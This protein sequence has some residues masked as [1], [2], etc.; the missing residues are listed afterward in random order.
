MLRFVRFF[1]RGVLLLCLLLPVAAQDNAADILPIT[2]DVI[3]TVRPSDTLDA[4]GALFDVSPVCIAANNDISRYDFLQIGQELLISV[5]C[6][7][8]AEDPSYLPTNTVLVPRDVVDI[9]ECDGVRTAGSDTIAGLARI[10][11][12]TEEALREANDLAVDEEPIFGTCITIPAPADSTAGAGG[13]SA[14]EGTFYVVGFGDTL[15]SIGLE[16]N[17]SAVSLQIANQITDVRQLLAG[18]TLFIPADAPPFG[19]YPPL[20]YA[21]SLDFIAGEEYVIQPNDTLD[22]IAQRFDKSLQAILLANNITNTVEL[23]PGTVIIIPDDAPPY[24]QFPALDLFTAPAGIAYTVQTGET[25]A[26]I[27]Q[28]FDVAL[29]ALETANGIDAGA[30]VLPGTDIIIP[31]NVPQYGADADFDA[32]MLSGQGGG[33]TGGLVHVVQPRDTVDSIAAEY[34]ISRDCLLE[35]NDLELADARFIQPGTSL[36]IDTTCPPYIGYNIPPLSD[37]V[38]PAGN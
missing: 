2:E 17:V 38:E 27:A 21:D 26:D 13:G 32:S 20:M 25:L 22:V 30:N 6:P 35:T 28:A 19:E 4:V 18:T 24:G 10:L 3:Y 15:N 12:V 16:L 37:A 7:R 5:A 29:I 1:I 31:A 23:M 33:G 9:A 11:G 36:A 14:Q 8:Y 34:G